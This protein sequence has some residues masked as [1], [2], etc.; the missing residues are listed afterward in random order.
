[1][2]RKMLNARVLIERN[3]REIE[4]E[5]SSIDRL[6]NFIARDVINEVFD[7]N[8]EP[9][10]FGFLRRNAREREYRIHA[11]VFEPL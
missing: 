5:S 1:M 9:S 8:F 3:G 4:R 2:L 11:Y 6:F 10:D 7:D